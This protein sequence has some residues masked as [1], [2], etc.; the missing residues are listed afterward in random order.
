M[1]NELAPLVENTTGDKPKIL[2]VEDDP[3]IAELLHDHL[4][5]SLDADLTVAPCARKA[6][7]L[8]AAKPAEVIVIDYMLPD[9]DGLELISALGTR[10]HRPVIVM[11]GHPTLSRAI[12]AMRLGAADMFV[13]PFDLE[14]MT[15]AIAGA[16]EKSR[17]HQLRSKRLRRVRELSHKVIAERRHLRRKMDLLCKDIVSEYRT[18]AEK[19]SRFQSVE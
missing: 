3:Q 4:E 5:Y 6:L 18:L 1:L 12:E 7:E 19:I 2:V 15:G 13:K 14:K 9:M 8:D 11:T 10:M 16:I 17:R